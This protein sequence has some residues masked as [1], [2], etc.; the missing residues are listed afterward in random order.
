MTVA[1]RATVLL[2]VATALLIVFVYATFLEFAPIY[3]SHDEIVFGSH[4]HAIA[5]S[6]RDLNGR[7]M[8]LFFHV[9][10][11][12][13]A[14]PIVIYT[15]ALFQ[16]AL[17]LS[18]TAIRLPSVMIGLTNLVLIYLVARRIFERRAY[19]FVAV[20]L[21]ALTPAHFIHSRL[22]VDHLYP[23]A[24]ILGWL[25]CLSLVM[26]R[27]RPGALFA[28]SLILGIGFYSY[29]ASLMMMPVYFGMTCLAIVLSYGLT[30]R[31]CLPALA[32]FLLPASLLVPW[33]LTH[34]TQYAD[35]VNLYRVYDASRYGPL[36]GLTEIL[37]FNGVAARSSI[38][39]NFF[40]PSFLFFSGDSSLINATQ[41]AG[42]FLLP[43]AL[44]L[45]LGIYRIWFVRRTLFNRLLLLGLAVAPL[46]AV[47]VGEVRM[48]RALIMLPFAVLIATFGVEQL[49]TARRP[50]WRLAGASL[51][52]LLPLQFGWFYRDYM[53]DY[54]ARSSPWFEGNMRGAIEEI[55]HRTSQRQVPA[56]YLTTD[57]Q[58]I[59]WY[60]RFY[61]I[62]YDR[63]EL[64]ER[65]V[66]YDPR[67]LEVPKLPPGSVIMTRNDKFGEAAFGKLNDLPHLTSVPEPGGSALFCVFD[68]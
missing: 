64:Q 22:A 26:E 37:S 11:S 55:L 47:L 41:R 23:A 21:L 42:V 25:L 3:L 39:Y 65:T 61:L 7:L 44:F 1:R 43:L 29:L 53:T 2:G 9:E 32:G 33:L 17:P 14:T 58:W 20:V 35:Q 16:L 15:M 46:A 5:T 67:T 6:G 31:R 62:K 45:P 36:G 27:Y 24:F 48:N 54:R 10:G 56:V 60:W 57:F 51:L 28:G 18:E 12:Y 34:P 40:N 38:Y 59:K 52:A 68:R 19:A 4:A 49:L 50:T 63:S 13:W 66:Y 8:P 30:L